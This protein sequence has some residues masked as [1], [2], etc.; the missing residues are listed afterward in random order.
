MIDAQL[1]GTMQ[2]DV[3]KVY[4]HR[5]DIIL[6]KTVCFFVEPLFGDRIRPDIRSPGQLPV[7]HFVQG[8]V[9]RCAVVIKL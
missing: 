1:R 5:I 7:E 3:Y 8:D 6:Q 4:P 2:G 9:P